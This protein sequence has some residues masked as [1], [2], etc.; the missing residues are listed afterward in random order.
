MGGQSATTAF[1]AEVRPDGGPLERVGQ[2]LGIPALGEAPWGTHFCQFF[3]GRQDLLD[4]MVPYFRA[5]LERNEACLLTTTD[6]LPV[7][8]AIEAL[9]QEIEGFEKALDSGQMTVADPQARYL[10]GGHFDPDRLL[11]GMPAL[12]EDA[13]RRGYTGRRG[14]TNE[15][16][17][18]PEDWDPMM[19][20]ERAL[21]GIVSGRKSLS[22]CAYPLPKCDAAHLVEVLMRHQ[23]ALIRHEN[24][25]LIEPSERKRATE[26]VE[27]MNVALAERTAELQAALADLRG[28]SRWVTHD[29]RAPLASI[30]SFGELLAEAGAGKLNDDERGMLDRIR[31]SAARMDHLITNILV[32]SS[33]QHAE[34]NR[35]PL[36]LRAMVAEVWS[37]VVGAG[38]DRRA[39]LRVY[40]LPMA[41]ADPTLIRQTLAALLDNAAKSTARQPDALVEVGTITA[42]DG[43]PAYYVRDNGIGFDMADA[44]SLFGAFTRLH[45]VGESAGTGL[46]LA[47]VKEIITRHGGRVWAEATPGLGA[48]FYFTLPAPRGAIPRQVRR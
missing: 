31:G 26:A 30:T 13:L 6:P 11:E 35:R 8:D 41:Q 19:G 10:V 12:V 23:F 17:M 2:D 5:G 34:L 45:S 20:M 39:N 22:M 48:T 21:N 4:F 33:A 27:Q 40:D 43:E 25:T 3:G 24:W 37:G 16:W 9:G 32:Y 1:D 15:N 38:A 36:D 44:D 18:R 42:R 46:G 29:L 14:C 7:D 47:V 28:F